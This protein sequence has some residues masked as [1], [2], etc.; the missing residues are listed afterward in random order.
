MVFIKFFMI[1]IF[2]LL[3]FVAWAYVVNRLRPGWVA[4][5][6]L[7]G[8]LG[9]TQMSIQ[10]LL[11]SMKDI[12]DVVVL[13]P[14][15]QPTDTQ[16]SSN[17]I[18]PLFT[19]ILCIATSLGLILGLLGTVLINCV[20]YHP[21]LGVFRS[22]PENKPPRKLIAPFWLTTWSLTIF[23]FWEFYG[24]SFTVQYGKVFSKPNAIGH[25]HGVYLDW[26]LEPRSD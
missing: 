4:V 18:I 22:F 20:F 12:V 11:E 3:H 17:S 7:M 21:D 14:E 15:L 10:P 23:L 16:H 26:M 8:L 25:S 6:F 9:A 24:S 5:G 2:S 1:G 13:A 19:F